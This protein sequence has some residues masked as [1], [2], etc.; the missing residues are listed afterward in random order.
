MVHVVPVDFF[1]SSV[2]ACCILPPFHRAR[3][4]ARFAWLPLLV[5]AFEEHLRTLLWTFTAQL[6]ERAWLVVVEARFR[7]FGEP[8]DVVPVLLVALKTLLELSCDVAEF[9]LKLL[10]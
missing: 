10:E 9:L 7:A 2:T 6:V 5:E 1:N 3:E 4:Y 8:L